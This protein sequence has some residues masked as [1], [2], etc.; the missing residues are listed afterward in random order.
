MSPQPGKI[1]TAQHVYGDADLDVRIVSGHFE[2]LKPLEARDI[3][4]IEYLEETA[5]QV[6]GAENLYAFFKHCFRGQTYY[7]TKIDE[8]YHRV[9][10]YIKR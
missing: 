1:P 3:L 9:W 4:L 2:Q 5:S 10:E 7:L 6:V 8:P